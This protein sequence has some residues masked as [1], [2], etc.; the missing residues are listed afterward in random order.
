M[1]AE[2]EASAASMT[3]RVLVCAD[4]EFD[5][6]ECARLIYRLRAEVAALDVESVELATDGVAPAGA[7]GDPIS[8][9]ALVVALS[10]S[11][12]VFP[13]LIATVRDWLGRQPGGH[14]VSLTVD[15]DT[16]ELERATADQQRELVEAFMRRH[17]VS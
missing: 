4:P 15:G 6:G 8:L 13:G 1:V 3:V 2:D 9:A 11:G 10:A 12:S 5:A 16:I 7:K 14:R 17:R